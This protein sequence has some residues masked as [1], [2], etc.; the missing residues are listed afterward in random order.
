VTRFSAIATALE[1]AMA[2]SP[3][4]SVRVAYARG[5]ARGEAQIVPRRQE[6][7]GQQRW[8]LGVAADRP[9]AMQR[10]APVQAAA[11][12]VQ[13]TW[14]Q[15]G[16]MLGFIGRLVTGQASSKNIS[17]VIGIAQVARAEAD[18]GVSRLLRFM[19]LLS[20]T[21]CIMN[22]LPI[23]VLDGGHLLYYL[24]ELVA[25]RPLSDR[26]LVAGQ[27]VGLVMLAGLITLAFYNDVTGLLS[28]LVS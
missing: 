22:L 16:E 3:G 8:L 2:S 15:T 1:A 28:R 18:Q 17:G 25:G 4:A 21:L 13:E 11:K 6:V 27:Y 10:Y 12:A 24:I 19:A 14:K 23:P 20:L 9:I 26:M 5:E 7:E